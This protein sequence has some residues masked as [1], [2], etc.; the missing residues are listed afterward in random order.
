M[1]A[2]SLKNTYRLVSSVLPCHIYRTIQSKDTPYYDIGGET[3]EPVYER[4]LTTEG[5]AATFAT[6]SLGGK[7]GTRSERI[8]LGSVPPCPDS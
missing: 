3:I 2:G 7:S 1:Q 4:V 6:G 5:R 8:V